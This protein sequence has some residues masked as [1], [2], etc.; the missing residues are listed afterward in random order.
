MKN[1]F[2]TLLALLCA[3][4]T[5]AQISIAGQV[6]DPK[7]EMPIPY[8]SI[9]IANTSIGTVSNDQGKYKLQIKDPSSLV[10]FS[11]IGYET[12][13]VVGSDLTDQSDISM[14][15]KD[16]DL[17]SIEIIAKKFE[18]EDR[19]YGVRNKTRGHS[20]GFGSRNLGTEIGAL[21]RIKEATY[22][23]SANFVL[24]HT[25]G[26][27]LLFRVNI[28]NYQDKN[29]GE[30]ILKENVLLR[31]A[32]K[33]GAISIDLSAYDIILENDVLL[34]LEWIRDDGDAGNAGITF[35]TKKSSKLK[36]VLIKTSSQGKFERMRFVKS[37]LKPCFYFVG[38]QVK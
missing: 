30:N 24:N 22:I 10:I 38:K 20:I 25:N 14:Q 3:Y 2:S 23:K 33:K 7:T 1:I 27:S 34:A 8:V 21:I 35:D 19:I 4:T 16:Y 6:I 5:I 18:G 12:V 36:G 31:T 28:Y 9:G 13:E 32:Q 29:I 26:D 15:S 11:A 37:R 17:E